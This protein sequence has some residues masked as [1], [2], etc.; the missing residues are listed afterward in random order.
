MNIKDQIRQAIV[1][2]GLPVPPEI[3]IDGKIHRFS[4]NR[5]PSDRA[6]YYCFWKHENGFVAGFFGDWRTG[7]QERWHSKRNIKLN[8]K[9][10]QK[11]DRWFEEKRRQIEE[12]RQ[13][14]AEKAKEKACKLWELASSE[15]NHPY[16]KNKYITPTGVK[17]RDNAPHL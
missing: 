5:K 11:I 12:Q 16:V 13:Q 15:I 7:I 2:A 10:K 17:Q 9:E 8:P 6:G 1:E 4:T 14:M 3:I